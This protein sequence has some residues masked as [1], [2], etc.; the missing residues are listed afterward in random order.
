M[1]ARG[2]DQN[3][4]LFKSFGQRLTQASGTLRK[5]NPDASLL[6]VVDAADNA[7]MAAADFGDRSF[8]QALLHEPLPEGCRLVFLCR[9]ERRHLLKPRS[10]DLQFGLRVFRERETRVHLQRFFPQA[11][12][13]DGAELHRLTAGNPRVQANALS[14]TGKTLGEILASLG[15]SGT[16]VEAQIN[17]QLQQA[18]GRLKDTYPSTVGKEIDAI[19]LGLANLPPFIPL[20]LLAQAAGVDVATVRSFATDL[21]RPLWLA[22]DFVQFRD[23]PTETWFREMFGA[24][25]ED[26]LR[27]LAVLE[28]IAPKSAYAA[29]A[30]PQLL[31]RAGEHRQLVALALSDRALPEDNLIDARNIRV[32]RLQFAFKAALHLQNLEDAARL[33]FR[34]GEEVAGDQRQLELL[35]K[36]VDLISV[37]QN[38]HRVQELASRRLLGSGWAGSENV[39]SASLLSSVDAFK[40]EA[41]GYLR[42]AERWLTLYFEERKKH[43]EDHQ[44]GQQLKDEDVAE[45][46]WTYFNLG[47]AKALAAYIA[48]WRPP[49]FVFRLPRLIVHRLVD[50]GRFREIEEL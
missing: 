43:K 6:I 35:G 10:T 31:H 9:S 41:R 8:A 44:L 25:K 18:V 48:K 49:A 12:D 24:K 45:F 27:Y 22:D 42:G 32:Y 26:L 50:A 46:A 28:P 23:E 40:G 34:A 15:P 47:G 17:A 39:Y 21:G 37:L 1:I 36:N 29:K 11:S 38:E 16:T 7:E 14:Q 3:R 13:A 4:D 20:E 33:A 5:D 19:C 30:L 2:S